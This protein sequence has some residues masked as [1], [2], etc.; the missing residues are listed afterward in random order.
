[1]KTKKRVEK[2]C[3]DIKNDYLCTR[4]I[5]GTMQN[6]D[7]QNVMN[8]L[9]IIGRSPLLM[10]ALNAA[11]QA[12]PFDVSVL[13]TG[14]NGAGKEVFHRI[15]HNYSSRKHKKCIAVNCGG[16]PEGTIDSELFGHVKGAFTGATSDR[17]GYFEEADGGTIFLDEIGELPMAT[18]ARLLRVLETGEYYH[19]GSSEVRRTNVRVVAATNVDLRQAI[20]EHKFREDLFYR[21]ST[22]TINVPSLRD[23]QDDIYL[24]FR[25]F[26]N[27][28]AGKY[29]MPKIE[30][31]EDARHLLLAYQWPG[32]VRQ[33]LHLVEEISI[34][35]AER[36]ITPEILQRHLP[37]FVSGVSVGGGS[38][39]DGSSTFGPGEKEMI[40]KILFEMRQQLIEVRTKLG[41]QPSS[42]MNHQH[43]H[44]LAEGS[45]EAGRIHVEKVLPNLDE[46]LEEI[47]DALE[48][49]AS[50]SNYK[51]VNT[52]ATPPTS[53]IRTMD[54]I[55]KEA[56]QQALER[57]NGNKRKAAEELNISER[58]IHR[59]IQDYGL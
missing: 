53:T 28:I 34:V 48:V 49:E 16:L 27:D 56:I 39:S 38:A 10:Q 20:R 33:L 3:N 58:T 59:K 52:V 54:E 50:G 4:F 23:R 5:I 37:S 15:L 47:E 42:N 45:P 40:Y 22:I 6:P 17:K 8:S 13:V 9:G 2:F 35:E 51:P 11:I 12:A 46:Q 57:N 55:E 43:H 1:M 32:N 31:T 36:V 25:K 26:A 21:L 14:E 19:V 18:Q 24:L 29:N 41:M 44:M 7:V 30:L